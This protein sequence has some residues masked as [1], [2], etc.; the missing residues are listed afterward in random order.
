MFTGGGGAGNEAIYRLWKDKY[1]LYFADADIDGIA[2]AIPQDRQFSIPLANH[3]AFSESLAALCRE[4][5]V[6]VLVPGV[7]E[8]LPKMRTVQALMEKVRIL[9]PR[10]EFVSSTLDKL[11]AAR[12][13]E[14]AGIDV[15]MTAPLNLDSIAAF[16][17]PCIAKPKHGRGSKGLRII[18]SQKEAACFSDL[19]SISSEDYIVQELLK[20]DEYTVL[21]AADSQDRLRATVPVKVGMKRGI[22]ISGEVVDDSAIVEYCQRIHEGLSGSACYNV[23]LM[24]TNSG[25]IAAFEINPRVSTTFCLGIMAGVDPVDLFISETSGPGLLPI[26]TGVSIRRHYQNEFDG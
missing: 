4:S 2:P 16:E 17:F 14:K 20:G 7:D 23:Q 10:A 21:V 18:T 22:T 5:G 11:E 1:N 12:V 15:P 6:D 19:C 24:K 3:T 25:R 13:L 9:V 8:E 26:R